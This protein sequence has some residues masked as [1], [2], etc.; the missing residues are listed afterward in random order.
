MFHPYPNYKRTDLKWF[1]RLPESWSIMRTKQMFRLVVEKASPNNQ[2]E[3]LSVYTHI[4]V[5]PRRNLE[6]RGNKA[7]TTDGYWIVKKGDIICNKLLAWMGAIGVSRYEGVTSP[8]Y[9]V[10]RPIKLCNTEYYHFL[11]RTEKYLQQ[12]K[13]R[14]RGIMDMRLRLYFEQFGQIPIPVPPRQE[15]D[16][17]VAYLR[18]QD[19]RIARFV[20]GRRALARLLAEQKTALINRSVTRGLSA[21]APLKPAGVPW[22]G[23]VP[24]HW[25]MLRLRHLANEPI[26]NG[27]GESAQPF[28]EDWPR[29]IRITDIAG[30]TTLK[31]L[32]QASLPPEIASGAPLFPGDL[33]FAAVGA[34]FGKSYLHKDIGRPCCYAGF[35]V[36]VSPNKL[37]TSEFLSL[38]AQSDFY[39]CQLRS[40]VIQATIQNFSASRYKDLL[41]PVPP[42]DEQHAI[43]Q[44]VA[45]QCRPLDAAI[46]HI[47][48]EIAL[49]LEYRQRQILDAVTG[50]IDL[51]GWQPGPEDAATEEELAALA[52]GAESET[53]EEDADDEEN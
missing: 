28:R 44:W 40:Q 41:V 19:A 3:L 47:E 22:L 34:T 36:K 16:Q 42:I 12:F 33:L 1:E 50:Q 14:A 5:R 48:K 2:M 23:D 39:W 6:Q 17:I 51:R 25:K 31:V 38:W 18:A 30:P 8:A 45:E 9:D 32:T 11:F 10:L 21:S 20:Q 46:A 27:V 49:V 26:K 4:G 53:Y 15:Q 24:E 37:A 7:S 52:G 35:L 29:Y 43:C 13:I